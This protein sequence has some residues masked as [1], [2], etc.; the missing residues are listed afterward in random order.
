MKRGRLISSVGMCLAMLVW[1]NGTQAFQA[2]A[3]AP[4][5][6]FKS[7]IDLVREIGRAHV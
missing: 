7:S 5:V 1:V 3:Q 2:S 4:S 6:T